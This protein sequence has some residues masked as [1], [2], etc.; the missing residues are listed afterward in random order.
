M[1]EWAIEIV[2]VAAIDLFKNK[3]RWEN[4]KAQATSTNHRFRTSSTKFCI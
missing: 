1:Q 4:E 3:Q 2:G